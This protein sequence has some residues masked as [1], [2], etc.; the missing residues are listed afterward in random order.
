[1]R[2][3]KKKSENVFRIPLKESEGKSK[4]GKGREIRVEGGNVVVISP[5]LETN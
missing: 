5:V 2:K 3:K 1:M 4:R